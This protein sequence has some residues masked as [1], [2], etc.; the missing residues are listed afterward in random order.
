MLE[1][2]GRGSGLT[3]ATGS[4]THVTRGQLVPSLCKGRLES[5]LVTGKLLYVLAV[6]RV[7]EKGQI[8]GHHHDRFLYGGVAGTRVGGSVGGIVHIPLPGTTGPLVQCK[9]VIDKQ[10]VVAVRPGGRI[11]SP[12][13]FNTRCEGVATLA[14]VG[15]TATV[16]RPRVLRIVMRAR[17][18]TS[19][20]S[21]MSL[22]KSMTTTNQSG[23]LQIIHT[24]TPESATNTRNRQLGHRVGIRALRIDV[25]QTNSGGTKRIVTIAVVDTW[26]HTFLLLGGTERK[27]LGSVRG[28]DAT[29]T[30]A[31]RLRKT[32]TLD[33][34]VTSQYDEISPRE[35]KTILD[36]DRSQ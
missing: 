6:D 27:T 33:S 18:C 8:G 30:E 31:E 5:R 15:S 14:L 3:E 7:L 11:R 25:D 17:A 12:R 34:S 36:L 22:A 26:C 20:A 1:R 32:H 35:T 2:L 10:T 16:S 24:H 23:S 4:R 21:T 29:G 9:G 13:A 19:R 28:I